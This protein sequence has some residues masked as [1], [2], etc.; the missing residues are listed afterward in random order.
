MGKGRKAILLK[1]IVV[2]YCYR[3]EDRVFFWILHG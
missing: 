3:G 1:L 2:A